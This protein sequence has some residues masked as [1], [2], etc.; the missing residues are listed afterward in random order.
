MWYR[1]GVRAAARGQRPHNS[2]HTAR[3][4]LASLCKV[5]V[6]RTIAQTLQPSDVTQVLRPDAVSNPFLYCHGR[7]KSH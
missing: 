3:M 1:G 2:T 4:R 5:S 6:C 7:V